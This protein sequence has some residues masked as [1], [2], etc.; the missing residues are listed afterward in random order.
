[1]TPPTELE[2]QAAYQS[3]AELFA[4]DARN[5]KAATNDVLRFGELQDWIRKQIRLSV[6]GENTTKVTQ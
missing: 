3:D 6:G 5:L 2:Q 4:E 1:M